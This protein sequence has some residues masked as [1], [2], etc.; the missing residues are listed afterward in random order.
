MICCKL[1]RLGRY[2]GLGKNLDTAIRYLETHD[3]LALPMGKTEIDGE[4]V[5]VNRFDYETVEHNIVEAHL[6]DI[7]IHL[8]LDGEEQ[9]GVV[10]TTALRVT[11]RNEEGDL[12]DSELPFMC[13]CKLQPGDILIVFPEDAHSPKLHC[14]SSGRVKKAVVKVRDKYSK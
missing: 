1:N 11:E 5:Y 2:Y 13:L 8:V 10:D 4:A 12:I 7:D 3:L 9:V 6:N 14:G